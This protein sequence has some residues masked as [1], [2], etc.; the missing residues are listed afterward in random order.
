VSRGPKSEWDICAGVL[1]VEEAG[2]RVSDLRGGE[3]RFNCADPYVHGIL[4]TNSV[5]HGTLLEHIRELPVPERLAGR[6]RD[7]LHPGLK[8]EDVQ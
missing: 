3:P 8:K 4:A 6:A 2:G 5:L 1:L 7:P